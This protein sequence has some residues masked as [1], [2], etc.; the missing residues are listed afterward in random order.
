[1][2]IVQKICN[3][4]LQPAILRKRGNARHQSGSIAIG[5]TDVVQ[6]VLGRFLLQLD[7]AALGDG[8]ES[9]LDLSAH[10]AGCVRQECCKLILEIVLPVRLTD[11]VQHGQAIFIL[12]QTQTT[13]ELLQEDRQ[14]FRRTQ[15]EYRIDFRNVHALVVDVHNE[16][17]AYRTGYQALL[18][19]LSLLVW[20]IAGQEH[21]R[22]MMLI[23]IA[24]HEF[25]VIDRHAEPQPLHL[26]HVSDIFQ[27]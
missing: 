2:V 8:N 1:M 16:N 21:G 13:A 26:V 24:A 17:K 12:S 19:G 25:R 23:K 14:G 10:A 6:N 22:N 3:R 20:G 4:Q 9:V 27:E 5:G 18:G 7:I 15:E 11:K